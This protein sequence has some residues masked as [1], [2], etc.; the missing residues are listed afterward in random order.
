MDIHA[1][2]AENDQLK[3]CVANLSGIL[4][5]E[6]ASKVG[7]TAAMV[8]RLLETLLTELDLK[9]ACLRLEKSIDG[10]PQEMLKTADL[11]GDGVKPGDFGPRIF[12]LPL[13]ADGDL[14][15]LTVGAARNDF[16]LETERFILDV[17]GNQNCQRSL[18]RVSR[19]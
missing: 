8:A 18:E 14:G 12:T 7:S 10:L 6:G 4:A 17:A 13:G 1:L 3:R 5:V 9:V 11:G 16:P 2:T 15:L 19:Q